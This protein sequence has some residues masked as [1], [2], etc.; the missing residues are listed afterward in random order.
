MEVNSVLVHWE[1]VI[2]IYFMNNDLFLL[3]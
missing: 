1:P 2:L 3:D